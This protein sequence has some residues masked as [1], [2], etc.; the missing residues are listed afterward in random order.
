MAKLVEVKS[1]YG[2]KNQPTYI[3]P[4]HIVMIT[5]VEIFS[6]SDNFT[7]I[8]FKITTLA[9]VYLYVDIKGLAELLK[10]IKE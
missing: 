6:G 9:E 5:A 4:D 3:N 2:A 8:E 10:A 7:R 1:L